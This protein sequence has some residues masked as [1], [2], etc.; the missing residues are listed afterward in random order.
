MGSSLKGM[1]NGWKALCFL[2]S[3]IIKGKLDE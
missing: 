2:E 1:I 3:I